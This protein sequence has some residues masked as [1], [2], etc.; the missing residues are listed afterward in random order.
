MSQSAYIQLVKGSAASSATL[1]DV[2][3]IL[4]Q[5]RKQTSATGQQLD[6]DYTEM[7][8]PYAIEQQSENGASW[9]YLKG[10]QSGYKHILIGIGTRTQS[11]EDEAGEEAEETST[12]YIQIVLPSGS[13]HG[14]K[15]KANELCRYI[16]RKL[17]AEVRLFNGRVMYFNPRK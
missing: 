10:N 1:E 17:Q 13:T 16:G 12:S 5:Y 9:L 2:L 6:W 8:F 3:H 4:E 14:D 15:A 7:A 11:A